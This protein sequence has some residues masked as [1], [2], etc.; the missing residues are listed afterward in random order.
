MVLGLG[1]M[2]TYLYWP[3]AVALTGIAQGCLL[4]T[5]RTVPATSG[6]AQR[7]NFALHYLLTAAYFLPLLLV[8]AAWPMAL[9][10]RLLFFDLCINAFSGK[11]LFYVGNTSAFDRALQW[12]AGKT[13]WS[14]EHV[15]LVLWLLALGL[16]A[17]YLLIVN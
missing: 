2:L 6:E 16:A 1:K 10:A 15:R 9:G 8:P 5:L 11:T 14:A 3:I 7:N 13:G 17:T 4:P 12:L